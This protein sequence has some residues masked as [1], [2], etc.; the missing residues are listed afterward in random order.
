MSTC[1]IKFAPAL[2]IQRPKTLEESE[3]LR[4]EGISFGDSMYNTLPRR[5]LEESRLCLN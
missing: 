4:K 2:R 3:I 1:S 5:R